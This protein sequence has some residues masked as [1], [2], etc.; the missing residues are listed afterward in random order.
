MTKGDFS[1]FHNQ[2]YHDYQKYHS[3]SQVFQDYQAADDAETC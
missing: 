3:N 2:D 1:D